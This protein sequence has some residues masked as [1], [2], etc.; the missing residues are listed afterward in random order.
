M[1][2]KVVGRR[3]FTLVELLVVIAIIGILVALL[4]PAIQAAREAARR[5]QCYNNLKQIGLGLQHYH[6]TFKVFPMGVMGR[7]FPITIVNNLPVGANNNIGPSWYFGCLP[8][9]EQRNIYD[10]IIALT[11]N[12][13]TMGTGQGFNALTVN[14]QVAQALNTL[15]PDYMRCPSSPLPVME[16]QT[17]PICMPSYTGIAGG[18]D[19]TINSGNGSNPQ[20]YGLPAAASNNRAPTSSKTYTNRFLAEVGGTGGAGA[21]VASSGMLPPCEHIGINGCSDGTSNTMIAA[22]QSDWLRPALRTDTSQFHGDPGWDIPSQGTSAQTGGGFLSGTVGLLTVGQL[23]NNVPRTRP[24]A[25]GAPGV[26]P[27]A[28]PLYNLSTV[29][30]KPGEKTCLLGS[31]AGGGGA[32]PTE[33]PGCGESRGTGNMGHNNPLQSPHTGTVLAA[34][35]DGSVQSISNT[36]DLGILLRLAIRDDGQPFKLD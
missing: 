31:A 18:T 23:S 24:G 15:V 32:N 9:C 14:A 33:L 16:S 29:R 1:N 4:L 12:G 3:G 19:I 28:S 8:Y 25:P 27:P 22:E 35:V 36:T 20:Q 13:G 10:K 5:T 21:I 30:W 26:W 2:R 7:S 11:R 6:D 17:G 34:L